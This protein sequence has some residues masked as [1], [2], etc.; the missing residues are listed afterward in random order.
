M[1]IENLIKDSIKAI[2]EYYI[3]PSG[4]LKYP[5]TKSGIF[6]KIDEKYFDESILY[7]TYFFLNAT[8][9]MTLSS[10]DKSAIAKEL[11][12]SKAMSALVLK[13]LSQT[14]CSCNDYKDDPADYF[15]KNMIEIIPLLTPSALCKDWEELKILTQFCVDSLNAENC[16]IKRGQPDALIAWF[17]IRLLSVVFEL[18]INKRK[19]F[20]P[21]KEKFK[22]Y[23]LIL[24]QWD[25]E[26]M[27][28]MEKFVYLLCELHILADEYIDNSFQYYV[29]EEV[30]TLFPYQ[31]IIWLK[32]REYKGLKNPKTFSH[33]LMQ[34]EIIKKLL[35]LDT[36][37]LPAPEGDLEMKQFL[38]WLQKKCPDVEIPEWLNTETK[39]EVTP[40]QDNNTIP[41]DFMK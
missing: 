7:R 31:I 14:L 35:N 39:E 18:P 8:I 27:I 38:E 20:A 34:T 24:E 3:L 19:P 36:S 21:A 33:P 13:T 25:T 26:N 4:K 23:Q 15:S 30:A 10:E 1:M 40:V 6:G 16:I 5:T 11:S 37:L 29:D 32:L 9:F 12:T 2:K 28:E 22:H 41:D 17:V